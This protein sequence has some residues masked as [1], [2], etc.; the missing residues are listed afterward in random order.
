MKNAQSVSGVSRGGFL[1]GVPAEGSELDSWIVVH[2]DNTATVYFGRSEFGQ[3]TVTGMLQIAAEEL[4]LSMR[5]M[6]AVRLDTKLTRDQG[7]QVSSS[8]IELAAPHLRAAAAEARQALLQLAA[9]RLG[10]PA[11]DLRVSSGVVSVRGRPSRSVT[12]GELIGDKRFD[13]EVTGNAPLK[14]QSDHKLVGTRVPRVDLPAKMAGTYEHM[15]H[16]RLPGML[17]GRVVRPRGQG[18]LGAGAKVLSVDE[19]SIAGIPG[20]RVVRKGDFI[21]V[22]A[23][24]E[25]HAAK[26]AS[27]IRVSWDMPPALPTNGGLHDS[28]RT[29]KT[30]DTTILDD[31]NVGQAMSRAAHTASGTFKSPYESHA[32]F[33]PSCALAD[34]R[35]D[36][37]LVICSTQNL[38]PTRNSLAKMLGMSPEQVQVRYAEGGGTFGH[39]CYDDAAHSAAILSQAVGQPV[40]VQF[41]C[42]DEFG[43]DNYGPAHLADV[44]AGVD[45]GGKI[46]AYEYQGWQHGWYPLETGMEL[47]YD[48]KVPELVVSSP[49]QM[50]N[51]CNA[52][53]MYDT[54]NRRLINHSVP[55][56][57]GFLK[58]SYLRSPL[59][60]SI[61]FGSEQ[62]I[63]ELA[64][65]SNTDPV[66]FRRRNIS[67]P[68]W[69]GVLEAVELASK[70]RSRVA[71]SQPK[72][73]GIL[74]GRGVALGT[75]F[76]S[77]GAAVA[78][79]QVNCETGQIRVT[80]LYG[81]LDAGLIINP[82]MVEQQI[83]GMMIQ[84][85]S[86][87]LMEEVQFNQTQVTSIDW[88]SYPILRY[89]DAPKLKAIVVSR[90]EEPSTGAGEEV[91]AAAGAAIANAFFDATGK[92]LYQRPMTPERVRAALA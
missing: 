84:A 33:A 61:S 15:Q 17:H 48:M 18:A 8:S 1:V 14:P 27:Q 21:G 75:H 13:L 26:A 55:S 16:V 24:N 65:L 68:R 60:L 71:G 36:G 20:A 38:Y 39:S 87:V 31:G 29:S 74:T 25:W 92:R 37:A 91:I 59:D 22:V 56:L 32:P 66:A 5:Q 82:S 54:P 35:P 73:G 52:G 41:T 34:V 62:I 30:T 40:R 58:G 63:D 64:Y 2:A 9:A 67:N 69:L 42:N 57:G 76:S 10:V 70:W 28:M 89:A 11:G 79:V 85:T 80:H 6:S 4:D 23:P 51:K 88:N 45:T 50:V 3:G 19:G 7:M 90:P 43:W 49:A 86:R 77:F 44:R 46:I 12:Y 72:R 78:Q 53:A 47:A 81:A 83:E